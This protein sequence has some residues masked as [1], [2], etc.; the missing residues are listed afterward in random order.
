MDSNNALNNCS[1]T[2]INYING[3]PNYSLLKDRNR[4]INEINEFY[5]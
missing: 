1:N 2:D 5:K 3:Y 4:N